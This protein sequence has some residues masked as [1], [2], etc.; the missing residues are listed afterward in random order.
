LPCIVPFSAHSVIR[1]SDASSFQKRIEAAENENQGEHYEYIDKAKPSRRILHILVPLRDA[2]RD[3]GGG[4]NHKEHSNRK[5]QNSVGLSL[6]PVQTIAQR[7][8]QMAFPLL[9]IPQIPTSTILWLMDLSV[10]KLR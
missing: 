4:E 8:Q 6:G 7:A 1:L 10:N 2:N 3:T 9:G 5:F